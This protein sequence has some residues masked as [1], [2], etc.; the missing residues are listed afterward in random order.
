LLDATGLFGWIYLTTAGVAGVAFLV[1]TWVL[2]EN[3][4]AA[5][6]YFGYSNV[7]L[8]VIFVAIAVDVLVLG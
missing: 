3:P 8:S 1:G 4:E 7:Y 5:M 6:R 2:R